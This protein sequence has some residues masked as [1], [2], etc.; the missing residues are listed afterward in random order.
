[1]SKKY[2]VVIERETRPGEPTATPR[3]FRTLG[4]AMAHAELFW[5]HEGA[6]AWV[7]NPSEFADSDADFD[8]ETYSGVIVEDGPQ[9]VKKCDIVATLTRKDFE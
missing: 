5:Q 1:M 4:R 3:R 2:E 7:R 8:N 9:D 6:I